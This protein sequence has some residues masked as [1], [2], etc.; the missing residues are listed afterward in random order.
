V[1]DY[2]F[3]G[4][5]FHLDITA[6]PKASD[7]PR[8]SAQTKI[9]LDTMS[10]RSDEDNSK[11]DHVM[12][13][14]DLLFSQIN[15]MSMVQQSLKAQMDL[16]SAAVDKY[17]AEQQMIAQQVKANG[18]AVAQ[19]TLQQFHRD[20]KYS[21]S[22]S[23]S[24]A[25]EEE[26]PFSQEYNKGKA[27]PKPKPSRPTKPHHSHRTSKNTLPHHTLPKM[28]FPKFDGNSPKEWIDKCHNYFEIY[29][30]PQGMWIT[31]A[32]MNLEGNA[33]KWYQAYKK[34][35]TPTDW[36]SFCEVVEEK[37]GADD[38]RLA[39]TEL[40]ALR[41]TTTVE[42]YTTAFQAL[43]FEITMHNCH[44]DDMFFTPH[45]INGLK[46]EIRGI[47]EAQRPTT[48]DRASLIARV[49]QRVVERSKN[50]YHRPLPLPRQNL[51]PRTDNKPQLPAGQ[52][53]RDRQLRDYR[54]ANGLCYNCGEKFEPG[55]QEVCSK[56]AK[57]Q[58]H[59]L[60]LNDLDRE[61]GD[62]VLNQLA[63]K[64]CIE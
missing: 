14:F 5:S 34:N 64:R 8:P 51:Q 59:A 52:L 28:P 29:S 46:E 57:L 44:Y 62:D 60:I 32:T 3:H 36:Q 21:D 7:P 33:S 47:V 4:A 42:E 45:Y 49:Q 1:I 19:L 12:G 63:T 56:R 50:R 27:V 17:S 54:K 15:D 61:L 26:N 37:F 35:N 10:K 9:L 55:H 48:V 22:E 25:Y 13:N 31:A 16:S 40:L 41:Q 53:W 58:A 20:A 18:Q 23:A 24:I 43:Q 39:M 6:P 30:I 38:Y 11:W 2:P